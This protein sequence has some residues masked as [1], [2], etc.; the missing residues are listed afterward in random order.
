M[1]AAVIFWVCTAAAVMLLR[2][3]K[4]AGRHVSYVELRR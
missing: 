2:W 4:E 1:I 3:A